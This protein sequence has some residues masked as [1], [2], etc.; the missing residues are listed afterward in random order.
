MK[1]PKIVGLSLLAIVGVFI[2]IGIVANLQPRGPAGTQT[3]NIRDATIV[4]ALYEEREPGVTISGSGYEAAT[5]AEVHEA[6]EAGDA[7]AQYLLGTFYTV[8]STMSVNGMEYSPLDLAKSALWYEKAAKQGLADAQVYLAEALEYG[9][10]V[11]KNMIDARSWYERAAEQDHV[12]GHFKL[13]YYYEQ[14]LG[15]LTQD[16]A[17]GIR[18]TR[19]A[20]DR[21]DAGAQVNLGVHY[22]HGT[23]VQQ[24]MVT[25][26][27]W[28]AKG[29]EAGDR[30][31]K[32]LT[33]HM[34]DN[35]YGVTKNLGEARRW[36]AEAAEEGHENAKARLK[37][38]DA[39]A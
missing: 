5:L 12:R 8:E 18:H 35:G 28:F 31:G 19:I 32:Y 38:L 33:G 26:A 25:A 3:T 10:G 36:Y 1:I 29:A 27:E 9:Q 24:D 17:K 22:Y 7:N 39:G 11:P 30:H 37:E 6:A 2:A 20:A 14:G 4:I 34:Y 23:G 21:G 15:G 16:S 13:G